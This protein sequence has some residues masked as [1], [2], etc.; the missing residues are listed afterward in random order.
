MESTSVDSSIPLWNGGDEF[1]YSQAQE[2]VDEFF[3]DETDESLTYTQINLVFKLCNAY[4]KQY[5]EL[6]ESYRK[7]FTCKKFLSWVKVEISK[8]E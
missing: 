3:K 1:M 7:H 4:M 2:L 8:K 5:M 6:P